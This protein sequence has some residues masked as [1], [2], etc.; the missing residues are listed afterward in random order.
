MATSDSRALRGQVRERAEGR[1]EYCLLPE[2]AD[3]VRFEVDHV[4]AE[5]HGGKTE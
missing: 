3:L 4:I 1:C 5:Q 2:D